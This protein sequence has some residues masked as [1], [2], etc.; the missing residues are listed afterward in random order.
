MK[1]KLLIFG[2][3]FTLILITILMIF[4]LSKEKKWTK[5]NSLTITLSPPIYD[6]GNLNTLT[7]AVENSIEYFKKKINSDF[8]YSGKKFSGYSVLNSLKDFKS[9]LNKSGLTQNFFSYIKENYL[10]FESQSGKVL[11]TGYFEAELKGSREQDDQ[12]RFPLYKTPEDLVKIDLSKFKFYKKFNS[13]PSVLR[14]RITEDKRIIPYYGRKEID[15]ENVLSGKGLELI[16]ID[17]RV[18][19]FFLQI[20]GSGIVTLND[21]SSIRVNYSDSNGHPYRSIGKY[22]VENNICS[23]DDLSMQ[24]IK[25]YIS[26]HPSETDEILN[27]NQS[28]VFF[29]EVDEGPVGS[30]GVIVTPFRTIATDRK[31][32]PK[33]ALCYIETKLPV[34]NKN[35]SISG[36]SAFKGFMLNQD[37]GG[38]IKTPGRADIFCGHGKDSELIAGHLKEYGKLYFL[39]K[40]DLNGFRSDED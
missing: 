34:F 19:L 30:L 14:G 6:S 40:K 9:E 17:N 16:W 23:Y 7:D 31:I 12:F 2:S 24:F 21:G 8:F 33:G 35:G 38:A 29:R 13:L 11:F 36:Y 1:K 20:Q 27:Y 3:V 5:E 18:D 4:I 15:N 26:D 10:F 25:K 37:T 32:F 22:L 28:Y 39:I